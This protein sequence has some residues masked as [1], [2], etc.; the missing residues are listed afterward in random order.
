MVKLVGLL[1]KRP[2]MTTEQF[3]EHWTNVHTKLALQFPGLRKYVIN[4]VDREHTPESTIDGFSE[5]W[6][7]DVEALKKAFDPE[8]ELMKEI[9][10][11]CQLFQ[12]SLE[13]LIIRE[14]VVKDQE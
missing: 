14:I 10:A 11:D 12:G 7:D 3:V 9:A 6:F 4:V 8:T 1:K 13:R 2:D 5:L